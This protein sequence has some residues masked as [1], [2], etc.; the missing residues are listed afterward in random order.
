MPT[1]TETRSPLGAQSVRSPTIGVR[2]ARNTAWSICGS[3]CSQGSALLTALVVA[4]IL[5]VGGFGKLA[6]VQTTVLLLATIGELGL[7]LTTTK[8]VGRWRLLD[9][10]RAGSLIGWSLRTTAVSGS[11]MALMMVAL[12]SRFSSTNSGGLTHEVQVACCWLLFEMLNRVQLGAMAGM[13]AFEGIA[14]IQVVRGALMFPCVAGGAWLG[15]VV[16]AL[17]GFGAAA[18]STFM[19]GHIVLSRYCHLSGIRIDYRSSVESGILTTSGSMWISSLLMT[20]ST[21]IVS[22][23]LSRQPTGLWELGIYNAADKWKTALLFVPN[24]LFQ[25]H[26]PMLS[27]SWAAGD[28]QSCRKL[29]VIGL[30]STVG[31]TCLAAL[32]VTL[33]APHLMALYGREFR[34]GSGVLILAAFSGLAS[35]LYTVGSGILWAIGRPSAM[36]TIDLVK[37]ILLLSLCFLGF[38]A[39]AW[40]LTLA[41]FISL[42]AGSVVVLLAVRQQVVPDQRAS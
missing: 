21:W 13:E 34:G 15:G 5:G 24:M 23:L 30:A 2:L 20:G 4:R 6:L 31:V 33:F 42:S 1:A 27:H 12:Q 40:D 17:M 32:C 38:A 10:S 7:S 16:G 18:A 22:I 19:I 14:R 37:T 25:V 41:Y 8:F 39:S 35:A 26:L 29:V 28:R 36:L 11:L 9:P 3:V